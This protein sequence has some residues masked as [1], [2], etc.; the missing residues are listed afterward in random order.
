MTKTAR[1]LTENWV[2]SPN[3]TPDKHFKKPNL[4]KSGS[5]SGRSNDGKRTLFAKVLAAQS[6]VTGQSGA[7]AV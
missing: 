1:P 7:I 5:L 4:N 6:D 3:E 2:E